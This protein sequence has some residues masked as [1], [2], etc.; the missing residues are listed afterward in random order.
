[1]NDYV[2]QMRTIIGK[3]LLF[4]VGCGC[5]IVNTEGMILLQK[6]KDQNN[7]CIPGGVMEVNEFFEETVRR[8]VYEETN[9]TLH[10][11]ELFGVYSGPSCYKEYPNGD[12]IYSVQIIFYS[13][14]FNGELIQEG[15]ESFEHK[16]FT[17]DALP[18]PLNSNQASFILDWANET[19]RPIIR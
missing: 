13:D 16:F 18:T 2:A 11:I 10:S 6:R 5:I 15:A 9:L 12:K 17:R 1:M 19:R 7:W 8:E 3:D 14:N 4:T